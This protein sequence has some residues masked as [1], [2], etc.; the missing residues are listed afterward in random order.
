MNPFDSILH[1]IHKN[2]KKL[3]LATAMNRK[4]K[5]LDASCSVARI[6]N[7]VRGWKERNKTQGAEKHGGRNAGNGSRRD[8]R[9]AKITPGRNARLAGK[10]FEKHHSSSF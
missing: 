7:E 1:F 9:L 3:L 2:T 5:L 10:P 6:T 8:A 4:D